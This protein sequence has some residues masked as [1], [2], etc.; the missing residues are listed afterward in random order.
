[1]STGNKTQKKPKTIVT[2]NEAAIGIVER[3]DSSYISLTDMAR[4]FGGDDLIYSWMRSHSTLEY[5]GT[6]EVIHNPNFKGVEFE[7]F[8][9]QSGSNTFHMTPKRWADATQAIGI[10]SRPGRGGGTFAHEDIALEFATWLSPAFKL[11]LIQEVQRLKKLEATR[12]S[13]QWQLNRQIAKLNYK[14]HT[15]AIKE[16]L[17]PPTI[18]ARDAGL[19]Y[20]SEADL[21]NKA[22]FGMTAK[23][24]R[25][26]NKGRQGNQ[27]DYADVAQLLVLSNLETINALL[28]EEGHSQAERVQRLNRIARHQLT[29]L[30]LDSR[31]KSLP[32]S[33]NEEP[34]PE[35]Q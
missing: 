17:I 2:V 13:E 15:G 26:E 31:W 7:T 27:R 9:A 32:G 30:H 14:L 33:G 4:Q 8:K 25:E 6:W 16:H 22:V 29:S 10:Y 28:I 20:A 1:M 19:T 34:E 21:L 5:L 23:E 3:N 24:W 35:E 12:A 18:S 11:Y